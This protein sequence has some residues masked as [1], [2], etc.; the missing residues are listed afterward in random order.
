[1]NQLLKEPGLTSH[2]EALLDHAKECV[3]K[4]NL[5]QTYRPLE[6]AAFCDG[7]RIEALN[8]PKAVAAAS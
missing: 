7:F 5:G 1:M 6:K 4:H 8:I 3:T 2:L